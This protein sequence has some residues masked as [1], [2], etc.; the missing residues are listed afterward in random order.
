MKKMGHMKKTARERR[1]P[2][3]LLGE[4]SG[5]RMPDR[6]G[7]SGRATIGQDREE[8]RRIPGYALGLNT[9]GPVIWLLHLVQ[10][11]FGRRCSPAK[12]R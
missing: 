4:S 5:G 2:L 3:V 8:Y 10:R 6:M 9:D 12:V 7:A 1:M 11:D